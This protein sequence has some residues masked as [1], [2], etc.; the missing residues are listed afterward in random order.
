VEFD[1]N[2]KTIVLF[3]KTAMRLWI[4][5]PLHVQGDAIPVNSVVDKKRIIGKKI[6]PFY[7]ANI[8]FEFVSQSLETIT[9]KV[10]VYVLKT[11]LWSESY[12]RLIHC[13]TAG[14][15]AREPGSILEQIV[16]QNCA[17]RTEF[18]VCRLELNFI[19]SV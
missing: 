4:Q 2:K 1:L 17:P 6:S 15:A 19:L 5:R 18:S 13:Q 11:G 14:L 12:N 16:F 3:E 8:D 7:L 9:Y 10:Q